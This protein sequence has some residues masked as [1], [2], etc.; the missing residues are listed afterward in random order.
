MNWVN[1]AKKSTVKKEVIEVIEIKEVKEVKEID[2]EL[3]SQKFDNNYDMKINDIIFDL[4]EQYDAD[5]G[6]YTNIRLV[7]RCKLSSDLYYFIKDN[8][9]AL[10][11][12]SDNQSDSDSESD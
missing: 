9:S 7:N 2:P 3:L 12:E 11:E 5:A 4:L 1:I 10:H 8:S 6:A